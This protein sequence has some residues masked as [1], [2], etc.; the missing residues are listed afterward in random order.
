MPVS[1]LPASCDLA[2]RSRKWAYQTVPSPHL[3]IRECL[4]VMIN[5][6]ELS[7]NLRPPHPFRGFCHPLP[8][9]PGLLVTEIKNQTRTRRQEQDSRFP[10][11]GLLIISTCIYSRGG[12]SNEE[13][14]GGK[15]T[16]D[17]YLDL[18]S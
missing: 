18:C 16:P 3:L 1:Y 15:L 7:P 5:Q 2:P 14:D 4:P 9:H 11:E 17:L 13:W 6:L 10:R 8:I 12:V